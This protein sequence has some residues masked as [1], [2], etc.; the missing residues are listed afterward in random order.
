MRILAIVNP[1]S[2]AGATARR[3]PGVE[4][5]LRQ[6]L[7]PLE[8]EATRGPRDAER[9]AREGVRA[10][11]EL[12]VVAGGDGT[13]S[14]TAAGL[15]GAGLG[16]YAEIA[17]LPLGT[18]GDF[19]RG[20]GLSGD[21]DAAIA[22]IA[23]GK[24]HRIDAGRIAFHDRRGQPATT[25]FVNIA[26]A[27]VSGLVTELVNRAPKALG[28]RLS[29]LIGT[30]RAIARWQA[31]PVR[32]RVDGT[33]VHEGPLDLAAVANGS[34]FGGGM[35]VAPAA[36]PDDGLFDVISIRGTS[37][38]RL[39]RHLPLLYDGRHLSLPDVASHRGVHVEIEPLRSDTEVCIEVDGEPLG[40]LPARFEL[41]PGA[42]ALR[43]LPP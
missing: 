27:G 38:A 8:V 11:V 18:G 30:L 7:G 6:A 21:L 14:E 36:R 43:G 28:G 26:S 22:R 17:P 34:H 4:A 40:R 39:L 16:R 42:L 33:V 3:W 20:L 37:R 15:L 5:K 13:L 32:I 25:H 29:F 9:I 31:A 35:R 10:G 12:V 2:R 19:V 41:L 23:A 1:R 24:V